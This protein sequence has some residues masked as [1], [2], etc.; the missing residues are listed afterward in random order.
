MVRSRRRSSF[1]GALALLTG[2]AAL[3]LT[4][5]NPTGIETVPNL[6]VAIRFPTAVAIAATVLALLAF[7]LA[8]SSPRTGAGLPFVALLVGATALLLAL[9][10]DLFTLIHSR[11]SAAKPATPALVQPASK[12]PIENQPEHRVKTIFDSDF[13]SSTPPPKS[14]KDRSANPDSTLT[15][16]S[17]ANAVQTDAAAV[18]R[19]A[20]ANLQDAR[21]HVMQ[22]LEST[23]PYRA[24][25]EDVDAA[26]A[27]LKNARLADDPGSPELIA[28][29]Q[30]ALS[31]RSKLEEL[32]SAAA[33][34]D[35]DY[36][37]AQRQL[38]AVQSQSK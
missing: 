4:R 32:I 18:I 36:Q 33:A 30:A 12:A 3:V 21:E 2:A 22:S 19:V 23:P 37:T 28:A 35:P 26:E 10:P 8:A 14:S 13:P 1:L 5:F 24:A 11:L 17:A 31:A 7:L 38:Q 29:S 9:K 20:R 16:S 27:K 25:K 6:P 34:H 15:S